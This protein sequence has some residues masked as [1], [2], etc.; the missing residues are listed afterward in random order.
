[1]AFS[2]IAH[3]T[4]RALRDRSIS[5]QLQTLDQ[6]GPVGPSPIPQGF[7]DMTILDPYLGSKWD[8]IGLSNELPLMENNVVDNPS[9]PTVLP[10]DIILYSMSFIQ[11]WMVG[12]M[13][14]FH[15]QRIS[16]L[17]VILV[18]RYSPPTHLHFKVGFWD[19]GWG[20]FMPQLRSHSL[21]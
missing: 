14:L 11:L 6:Y 21:I 3:T 8:P 19:W 7:N 1:M 20:L 12:E 13:G 9:I 10:M 16:L 4:Q 18:P 5:S 15:D 2:F 17:L